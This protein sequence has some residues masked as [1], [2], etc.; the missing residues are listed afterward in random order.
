[1]HRLREIERHHPEGLEITNPRVCVQAWASPAHRPCSERLV[2][3]PVP[4]GEGASS[5]ISFNGGP[6]TAGICTVSWVRQIGA[7]VWSVLGRSASRS[8]CFAPFATGTEFARPGHTRKGA[9]ERVGAL[10]VVDETEKILGIL[11]YVDLMAWL[12]DNLARK[13][14]EAR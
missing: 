2:V 11:S 6:F 3:L 8:G 5:P 12:R 1:M 7:L 14:E 9:V 4:T 13:Q 10:P